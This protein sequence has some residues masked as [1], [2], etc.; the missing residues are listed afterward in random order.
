V[1][2]LVWAG[3]LINR[4]G[5]FG[6][7][8]QV[9][10]TAGIQVKKKILWVSTLLILLLAPFCYS[11]NIT[12]CAIPDVQF[13]AD[14]NYIATINFNNSTNYSS[15]FPKFV[16]THFDSSTTSFT[17]IRGKTLGFISDDFSDLDYTQDLNWSIASSSSWSAAS[18]A[19]V[20]TGGADEGRINTFADY[21]SDVN[22][23][24]QFQV[25]AGGNYDGFRFI[26]NA[27]HSGYAVGSWGGTYRL[28]RMAPN[29]NVGAYLITT[30]LSGNN[31]HKIIRTNDGNF[32][33]Y[34]D[35][36][37]Q[38]SIVDTTYTSYNKIHEGVRIH[39]STFDDFNMD[40]AVVGYTID[41]N[42]TAMDI[43]NGFY[44]QC[45]MV[46]KNSALFFH[47]S[48]NHIQ[49]IQPNENKYVSLN[50]ANIDGNHSI[51]FN[52][53]SYTNSLRIRG[54]LSST[55][56]QFQHQ[57]F[58]YNLL[59]IA[60]N[61]TADF[62]CGASSTDFSTT[63]TCHLDWNIMQNY[64][65]DG[66]WFID[67]NAS[68]YDVDGNFTTSSTTF[69]IDTN[70]PSITWDGN[71]SIWQRTDANIHLT[72]SDAIACD[73]SKLFYVLDVDRT[74]N[75]SFGAVSLF[76]KNIL[77]YA[78]MGDGNYEIDFNSMD[79][80]SN[81]SDLNKRYVLFDNTAPSITN[82]TP[83]ASINQSSTLF[84]WIFTIDDGYGSFGQSCDYNV[85]NNNVLIAFLENKQGTIS[86]DGLT[87]TVSVS[88]PITI[89][90]FIDVNARVT[91]KVGLHSL[92]T[93]SHSFTYVPV[94]SGGEILPGPGGG[95]G[96]SPPEPDQNIVVPRLLEIT[97]STRILEL[98]KTNQKY[99]YI[100]V[101]SLS[102]QSLGISIA[103]DDSIRPFLILTNPKN[104]FTPQESYIYTFIAQIED[105]NFGSVDGNIEFSVN[106]GQVKQE[107]ELTIQTTNQQN[108]LDIL[109]V[110]VFGVQISVIIF[111]AAAIIIARTQIR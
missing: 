10:Q 56:S 29:D 110:S 84:T 41:F 75:S 5:R 15:G 18:G 107:V 38:G 93:K 68:Y 92:I 2:R 50:N 57:L 42:L 91:D 96:S 58:D 77:M 98:Y 40:K 79:L 27:D 9:P 94:S 55:V 54:Y 19:L 85:Y 32:S 71:D 80:A 106:S 82:T 65:G 43:S 12:L 111:V 28:V 104:N 63:R 103:I 73:S 22:T 108:F 21:N 26:Y 14:T 83:A 31:H 59:N 16:V 44:Y 4:F 76:D 90:T 3:G 86:S 101:K 25:S 20:R 87:C 1:F 88:Y 60:E 81:V 72:C 67:L 95:G 66:N 37:Y 36:N 70:K 69:V 8:F 11:T 102:D 48:N 13:I 89:G 34:I 46:N 100:T 49:I 33:W 7:W 74:T 51:D 45:Q 62:N 105:E 64:F 17:T 99:Y 23:I 6:N 35:S 78:S 47:D 30:T 97:P 52:I 39:D 109:G 53:L 24:W 61:P